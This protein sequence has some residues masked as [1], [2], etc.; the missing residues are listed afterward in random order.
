MIGTP[1]SDWVLKL[2]PIYRTNS[3]GSREICE[4]GARRQ[5]LDDSKVLLDKAR[6]LFPLLRKGAVCAG[7]SEPD[8]QEEEPEAQVFSYQLPDGKWFTLATSNVFGAKLVC[9]RT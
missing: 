9:R 6:E 8:L 1:G 5:I 3:A 4:D 7:G 2:G